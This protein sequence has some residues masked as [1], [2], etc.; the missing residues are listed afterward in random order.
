MALRIAAVVFST[1]KI[2]NMQ[3]IPAKVVIEA[4]IGKKFDAF[5]LKADDTVT[6][7][8]KESS[9]VSVKVAADYGSDHGVSASTIDLAKAGSPYALF[10]E[11][12]DALAGIGGVTMRAGVSSRAG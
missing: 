2:K 1:L 5:D 6:R 11:G 7:S 8:Y 9:V 10:V 12:I 3:S 4:P